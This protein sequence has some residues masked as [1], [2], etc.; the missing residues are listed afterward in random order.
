MHR[1]LCSNLLADTEPGIYI[2]A[3]SADTVHRE[4]ACADLQVSL[5]LQTG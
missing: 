5:H 2:Q 4:P 1:P 3:R